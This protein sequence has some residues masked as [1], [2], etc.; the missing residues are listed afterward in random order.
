MAINDVNQGLL[1]PQ[2]IRGKPDT[3]PH[4]L[5]RDNGRASICSHRSL[6]RMVIHI[7]SDCCRLKNHQFETQTMFVS[8]TFM[9]YVASLTYEEACKNF[10]AVFCCLFVRLS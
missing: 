6:I 7:V 4:D 9:P 1:H 5:H 2:P 10:Q 3:S 8:T